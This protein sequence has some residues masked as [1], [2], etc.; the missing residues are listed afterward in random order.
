MR[1]DL[2]F[3]VVHASPTGLM[4]EHEA[5]KVTGVRL[6]VG[7]RLD[8]Q[9][10]TSMLVYAGPGLQPVAEHLNHRRPACADLALLLIEPR[11]FD[12]G[13]DFFKRRHAAWLDYI[14]EGQ[15]VPQGL[16]EAARTDLRSVYDALEKELADKEFVSGIWSGR[17]AHF[18]YET[19]TK[20]GSTK[21]SDRR[22]Q[23]RAW[24]R[25]AGASG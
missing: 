6:L 18:Q 21:V 23:A 14:D 22:S 2:E 17:S 13:L 5:A 11:G 8:L 9:C 12:V 15:D 1:G 20:I 3:G 25:A 7:C 16:L 24:T 10:G 4:R 19:S